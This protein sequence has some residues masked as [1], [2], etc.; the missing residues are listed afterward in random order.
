MK[1][2]PLTRGL[3]ALVDNEDYDLV[4]PYTWF[5][6]AQHNGRFCAARNLSL[7]ETGG[8]TITVRMARIIMNAGLGEFID[9]K[10][11]NT[12]DNRR[13]NLRFCTAEQNNR[14]R[15]KH[16]NNKSGFKGVC[17]EGDRWR[18]QISV[19]GKKIHLGMFDT[20]EAAADAY[21]DAA[22]RLH[23]EFARPNPP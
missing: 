10:N 21:N 7:H 1:K 15:N 3:F 22:I 12:L 17:R 23:G 13:G 18:S 4:S 20:A 8:K 2:I 5:A 11:L 6:L 16:H 14:N 9:H 19:G